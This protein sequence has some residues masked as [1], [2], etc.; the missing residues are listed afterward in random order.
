M[1]KPATPAPALYPFTFFL[2]FVFGVTIPLFTLAFELAMGWCA[3][4]LFDPIPSLPYQLAVALVG[5]ANAR[6]AR[7]MFAGDDEAMVRAAPLNALTLGISLFYTLAFLPMLPLGFMLIAA[8]GLG[9]LPLSPLFAF[10]AAGWMRVTLAGRVGPRISVWPGFLAGFL[11]LW[12]LGIGPTLAVVGDHLARSG[13]PATQVQGLGLLRR[14]DETTVRRVLLSRFDRPVDPLTL[15]LRFPAIFRDRWDE[16]APMVYFRATGKAL[17]SALSDPG[18]RQPWV[19]DFRWFDRDIHQGGENVGDVLPDLF[20][21]GSSIQGVVHPDEALAYLEWTMELTN[22]GDRDREARAELLLPPGATVSRVT[23]W[24]DGKEQEAA[25]GGRSRVRAAYES[26]VRRQRDPLLVTT[27]GPDRVLAQCFPV[28]PRQTMRIRLG[29]TCP[30]DLETRLEGVLA[31]PRPGDRNYRPAPDLT[32]SLSLVSH[33]RLTGT[34][35]IQAGPAARGWLDSLPASLRLEPGERG[36]VH[37]LTGELPDPALAGGAV[38]ARVARDPAADRAWAMDSRAP[39]PAPVLQTIE[40][41]PAP[42]PS[43]L[44][45]VLDLSRDMAPALAELAGNLARLPDGLPVTLVAAGD[46]AAVLARGTASKAAAQDWEGRVRGLAPAGGIDAQDALLLALDEVRGDRSAAV[47]WLHGAQPVDLGTPLALLD[48][49]GEGDR[50]LLALPATGSRNRLVEALQREGRI[51][52][53]GG[54]GS[55]ADRTRALFEAWS[56]RLSPLVATRAK[57]GVLPEG[58][59]PEGSDHL[60]RLWA[61]DE[62]ERLSTG[63]EETSTEALTLATRWQLVTPV[64]GAVVLET[65][66]QYEQAGLEPADPKSVPGVPEPGMVTVA[67]L[68]AAAAGLGRRRARPRP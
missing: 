65:R 23:L 31:L 53:V 18:P 20:L 57:V 66:E 40:P 7:A 32:H 46:E 35:P 43:R 24:I 47:L 10:L 33:G 29:M 27:T 55:V 15:L 63:A 28:L 62:V 42:A 25:F 68:A 2:V 37:A 26:V 58:L 8:Y 52:A 49:L 41:V 21:T 3:G 14:L 60:V 48:R 6:T 19:Q 67:L 12:A 5:F 30:L 16:Q 59:G 22:R 50:P 1:E 54:A 11:G 17:G 9:L 4:V 45:V 34:G 13:S 61:R 38:L 44:V 64:S 36:G 56:G 51:R 39:F